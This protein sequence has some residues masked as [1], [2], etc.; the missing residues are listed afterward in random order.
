VP[1][2]R[3]YADKRKRN[4]V[5]DQALAEFFICHI[6]KDTYRKHSDSFQNPFHPHRTFQPAPSEKVTYFRFASLWSSYGR[7]RM[8]LMK[9]NFLFAIAVAFLSVRPLRA[10]L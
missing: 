5:N 9:R 10:P 3:L 1:G 8:F 4:F 6:F 2:V 7:N